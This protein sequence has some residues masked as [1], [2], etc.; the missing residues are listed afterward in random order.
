MKLRDDFVNTFVI[1]SYN[2]CV[3]PIVKLFVKSDVNNGN[4]GKI[5]YLQTSIPPNTPRIVDTLM[6][7]HGYQLLVD[8]V[9]NA[10]PHGGK[11]VTT[12]TVTTIIFITI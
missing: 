8:G 5:K 9:F 12:S 4:D 1:G 3:A 6:R 7:V 11:L 10:D 2:V